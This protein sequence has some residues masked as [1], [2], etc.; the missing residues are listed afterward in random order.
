[1]DQDSRV[2]QNEDHFNITDSLKRRGDHIMDEENIQIQVGVQNDDDFDVQ[3]LNQTKE[4]T[5]EA[6]KMASKILEA[7]DSNPPT[8]LLTNLIDDQV[9]S[10][11]ARHVTIA[12]SGFLS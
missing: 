11:E 3:L 5:K 12:I 10:R 4:R 6:L 8:A 2:A 7:D 1:M 9:A